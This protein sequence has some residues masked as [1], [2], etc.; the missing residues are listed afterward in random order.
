MTSYNNSSQ[1]EMG[2][3]A[4]DQQSSEQDL[5]NEPTPPGYPQLAARMGKFPEA[6]I[7][8]NFLAL[9]TQNLLY[10]QAELVELERKLRHIQVRDEKGGPLKKRLARDWYFLE[11][12]G[13][14]QWELVREIRSKLAE[15]S[16]FLWPERK[17]MFLTVQDKTLYHVSKVARMPAPSDWDLR[18]VQEY[19]GTAEMGPYALNGEDSCLWGHRDIPHSPEE[20]L[21]SLVSRPDKD[22]DAFSLWVMTTLLRKLWQMGCIRNRKDGSSDGTLSV[23]DNKLLRLTYIITSLLSSVILITSI[24]VLYIV[25]PLKLRLGLIA[26]LEMVLTLIL[27]TFTTAKRAEVFAITVAYGAICVVFIQVQN[28]NIGST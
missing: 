28:G 7:F 25:Q 2:E 8:R 15:F 3:M 24:S 26:A 21:V 11:K 20:D 27:A 17:T 10:L 22:H 23:E 9:N 16:E 5:S 6:A 13:G 19:F 1:M 18:D 14:E 4:V 12:D